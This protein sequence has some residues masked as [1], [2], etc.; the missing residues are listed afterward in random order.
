MAKKVQLPV[1]GGIRKVVQVGGQQTNTG[2][3]IAG[4]QGQTITIAQLAQLLGVQQQKPNTQGGGSGTQAALILG[5]G[6]GGG[7][8]LVG[9]VPL[10][11]TAPIPWIFGDDGGGGGDGEVG[12]PGLNG[13]Q[14]VTGAVGPMGPAVFFLPDDPD[15]AMDAI[16]GP[17]GP[18]GVAGPQGLPGQLVYIVNDDPDNE[19]IFVAPP[20]PLRTVNKGANWASQTALITAQANIVYVNCPLPGTIQKVRVV[21][22][23]G[24]GSCVIDVWKAPFGSFPPLVGNSITASDKPTITLGTTYVDAALTGWTTAINA[25]DILAFVLQSTSVFTQV[26]VV[27]EISQ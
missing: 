7:G 20:S 27:L 1:V 26:Q 19:P 11:I 6:L 13:A 18:P 9:A 2:T 3:T 25:G 5:P 14:G 21:T 22:A 24:N 12:P 8:T 16:P 4:L 10:N 15:T 23:G 17:P